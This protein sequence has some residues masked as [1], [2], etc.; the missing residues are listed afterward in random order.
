MTKEEIKAF[1][2]KVDLAYIRQ[3][4]ALDEQRKAWYNA[5][6]KKTYPCAV[7]PK[8]AD[9]KADRTQQPTTVE[10][11]ITFVQLKAEFIATFFPE[12]NGAKKEK[13]ANMYTPL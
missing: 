2:D 12:C 10:R 8:G 4:C 6:T 5:T 7:F 1:K 9:G 13:K 3:Y 11:P